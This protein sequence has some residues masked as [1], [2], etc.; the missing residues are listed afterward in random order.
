MHRVAHWSWLALHAWVAHG[1]WLSTLHWVTDRSLLV[2]HAWIAHGAGLCRAW[3]A[4][5]SYINSGPGSLNHSRL[6]L[7][8]GGLGLV[9]VGVL[10]EQLGQLAVVD[11][12][13][14]RD[15][16]KQEQDKSLVC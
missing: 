4:H 11:G 1:P 13:C 10:S 5:R 8:V 3:V 14:C 6:D 16:I 12:G 9:L 2:H 7:G 15:T